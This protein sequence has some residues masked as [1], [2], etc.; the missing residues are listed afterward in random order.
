[1]K[2]GRDLPEVNLAFSLHAPTQEVRLTLVPSAR[3]Y[4]LDR[5]M[6]ALKEYQSLTTKAIMIEYIVIKVRSIHSQ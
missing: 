2:L 5:L 1:M 4:T 3:V 6:A